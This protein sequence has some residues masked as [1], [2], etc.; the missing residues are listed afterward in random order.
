MSFFRFPILIKGSSSIL[1][2]VTWTTVLLSGFLR[3]LPSQ[4]LLQGWRHFLMGLFFFSSLSLSLWPVKHHW[5]T[6][7]V[8]LDFWHISVLPGFP[9][10]RQGL[11]PRFCSFVLIVPAC[12]PLCL[13]QSPPCLQLPL[14]TLRK[15]YFMFCFKSPRYF[16]W[17]FYSSFLSLLL[18]FCQGWSYLLE[19]WPSTPSLVSLS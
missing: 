18:P 12:H 11:L 1:A 5:E 4:F 3:L 10:E 19:S 13:S 7:K 15:S 9:L 14:F 16:K 6:S 2:W 8:Q 17:L